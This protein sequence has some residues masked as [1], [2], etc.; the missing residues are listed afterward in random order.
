MIAL[1]KIAPLQAGVIGPRLDEV[2]AALHRG[3]VITVV[4]GIRTLA[5]VAG[6]SPRYRP[7]IVPQLLRQLESCLPRD[8]PTHALSCLPVINNASLARFLDVLERR[9]PELSSSQAARRGDASGKSPDDRT[10]VRGRGR[11]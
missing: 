6:A 10:P 9:M 11:G 7:K 4:W 5:G 3:S 1:G 8:L 2:L